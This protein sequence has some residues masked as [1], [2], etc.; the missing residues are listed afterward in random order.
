MK[1]ITNYKGSSIEVIENDNENNIVKLSLKKEKNQYSHYYN[2]IIHNDKLDE[3]Y[4]YI[5]NIKSSAYYNEKSVYLPYVKKEDNEW[6]RIDKERFAIKDGKVQIKIQPKEKMEISLVP[7]YIQEDLENFIKTISFSDDIIIN[8]ETL[9]KIEIG[10]ENL[11]TIFVIARQHPGET[12]SSFFVEGMIEA[13]LENKE[14]I[15]KHKFVFYPIAN[16]EGVKSGNHRYTKEIDF[17]RSWNIK[18][19]PQEIQFLKEQLK[20]YN[21]SCFIDVHNDEITNK[22]YLRVTDNFIQKKE[23]AGIQV[24]DTI[25]PFKRFIRALIKQRKIINVKDKTARNFVEKKYKCKSILIELSM[26]EDY[27]QVREKGKKFVIE[28]CG[29]KNEK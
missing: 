15:K 14:L 5:D 17:N 1:V 9:T 24:L 21:I 10:K 25:N 27:K 4:I 6:T 12:L 22:D 7:R 16:A 8:K 2:F 26:N 29:G 23:M 19:P 18:N 13:I 20:S 28:L 11:P 3:G